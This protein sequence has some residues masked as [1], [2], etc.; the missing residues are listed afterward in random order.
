MVEDD[1]RD[2][3]WTQPLNPR[4]DIYSRRR[5]CH[6]DVKLYVSPDDEDE[7]DGIHNSI[8]RKRTVQLDMPYMPGASAENRARCLAWLRHVPPSKGL[9]VCKKKKAKVT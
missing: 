5:R 4:M 3:P 9:S 7:A 1:K 8:I 6:K 2:V